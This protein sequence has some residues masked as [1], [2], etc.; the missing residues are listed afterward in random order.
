MRQFQHYFSRIVSEPIQTCSSRERSV[1]QL[2][3]GDLFAGGSEFRSLKAT[4]FHSPMFCGD[5]LGI[6]MLL[7]R[8]V[9]TVFALSD[10]ERDE[11]LLRSLKA[12]G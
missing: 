12:S 6:W 2:F 8:S 3:G 1:V 11:V 5:E 7:R 10:E 4:A 9:S